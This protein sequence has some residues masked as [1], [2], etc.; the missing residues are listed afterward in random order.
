MHLLR[1]VGVVAGATT[2][3]IA[4]SASAGFA[5]ECYIANQSMKAQSG[6]KS[7]AWYQLDLIAAGAEDFGW[8]SEET[9]CV[10]NAAAEQG[11]RTV[12]TI[13]V[14][15]PAPHDGV[16]GSKNPHVE[17]KAGDSKGIDHLFS[18]G[19]IVPLLQIADECGAPVDLE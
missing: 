8:S 4:L 11:V 12:Y 2:A 9:E 13:M 7:Q 6:V 14:K 16:L 19:A 5:H 1:R 3:T 18:G 15:V 10:T 17:T